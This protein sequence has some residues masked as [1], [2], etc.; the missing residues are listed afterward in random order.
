MRL[1]QRTTLNSATEGL[2]PA[3]E[4]RIEGLLTFERAARSRGCRVLAGID[5]A[6][7]GCLAGPV[8]AAACILPENIVIAGINDSKQLT[9]AQRELLFEELC[10][11]PEIQIAIGVV[12][13]EEIDRINI[14]QSSVKAMLLAVENLEVR[15]DHLLVDG[16]KLPH[17]TISSEKIIKGDTLSLSI[18]AASIVAK[19]TRD[20]MMIHEYHKKYPCYGF[21]KHKGYGTEAHLAALKEFGPCLIHRYSYAPVKKL[22]QPQFPF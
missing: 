16:M 15:P 1:L 18:A 8:V 5:E 9:P 20:R 21:D 19:V 17:A 22:C 3:E 13:P 4:A 6:G 7:R 10:T 12:Y 2:S 14:F 11:H